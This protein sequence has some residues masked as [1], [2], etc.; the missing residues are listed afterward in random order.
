[1]LSNRS[2]W[3]DLSDNKGREISEITSLNLR[4]KG[5]TASE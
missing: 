1:M 3:P 2:A 4:E 5:R